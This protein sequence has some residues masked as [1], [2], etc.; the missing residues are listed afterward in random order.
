MRLYDISKNYFDLYAENPDNALKLFIT[1]IAA[2]VATLLFGLLVIKFASDWAASMYSD[3]KIIL[4]VVSS[5][6][7]IIITIY[8]ALQI[9]A[10]VYSW[11]KFKRLERVEH[12]ND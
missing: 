10:I 4:S 2:V 5:F 6:C 11:V 3:F 1:S 7:M 8:T 9:T 12:Q